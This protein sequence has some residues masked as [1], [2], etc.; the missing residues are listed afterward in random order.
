MASEKPAPG[1]FAD[2]L[3]HLFATVYP[4]GEGPYSNPDVAKAINAAAGEQ[5]ITS[6]YIWQLR[7]GQKDNPTRRHIAAL[8]EFF[9]V[10]PNYF[11]ESQ[12]ETASA[13][14]PIEIQAALEDDAVRQLFLTTRGLSDKA[15]RMI[16]DM[17]DHTR[18][19]EGL[20]DIKE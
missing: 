3:N 15:L 1:S 2:R 13:P 20:P 17:V 11:F 12:G 8:A 9:G 19:L 18:E 5:V 6:A 10:E 14:I 16:Q 7:K 4:K